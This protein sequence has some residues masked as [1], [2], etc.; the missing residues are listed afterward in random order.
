[1]REKAKENAG[2]TRDLMEGS[3]SAGEGRRRR[4]RP[5]E[6]RGRGGEVEDDSVDPGPPRLEFVGEEGEEV[7]AELPVGFDLRG[8]ARDDDTV[9]G[10]RRQR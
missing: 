2:L 4:N 3:A 9:S 6:R 7:E 5:G 8:D 10:G 1:M